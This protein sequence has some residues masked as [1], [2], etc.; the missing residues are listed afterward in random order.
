MGTG[1]LCE[2]LYRDDRR[3]LRAAVDAFLDSLS[4]AQPIRAR[5][6]ALAD[7]LRAQ[8]C[9]A[10]VALS[11]DLNDSEPAIQ[12]VELTLRDDAKRSFGV[13]LSP[14]HLHVDAP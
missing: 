9:V 11:P 2:A 13:V 8:E 4:S 12:D 14:D 1:E 7:W 6:L 10:A 3:A 5:M